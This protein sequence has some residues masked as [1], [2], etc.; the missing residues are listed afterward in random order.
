M[1]FRKKLMKKHNRVIMNKLDKLKEV[2]ANLKE[3][4][5][6]LEGHIFV[7]NINVEDNKKRI[8]VSPKVIVETK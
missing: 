6:K 8:Q 1:K 3:I 2:N 7:E 4:L 5:I